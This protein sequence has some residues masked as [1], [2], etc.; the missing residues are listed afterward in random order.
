ML[1][2]YFLTFLTISSEFFFSSSAGFA[3][4]LSSMSSRSS[5]SNASS[6]SYFCSSFEPITCIPPSKLSRSIISFWSVVCFWGF[7]AST[8]PSSTSF[9]RVSAFSYSNALRSA[10]LFSHGTPFVIKNYFSFGRSL[11]RCFSSPDYQLFFKNENQYDKLEN[12]K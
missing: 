12:C 3:N 11:L 9:S 4:M 6:S 1:R 8:H 10:I 5:R 7:Y 2:S